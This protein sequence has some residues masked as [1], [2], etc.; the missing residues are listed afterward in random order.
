MKKK[1]LLA[2][3][4]GTMIAVSACNATE[5]SSVGSQSA[6]DPLK[7]ITLSAFFKTSLTWDTEVSKEITKR[8]GVSLEFVPVAGDASEKLN[9]MLASSDLPDI[10]SIDRGAAANNKYISNGAVIPLDDLIAKRGSNIAAQLGDTY[11][12]IK[13]TDGKLYGLPSWFTSAVQPSPVFGFNIRMNYVKELGYYDKYVDK[14]YFTRDEFYSLLKDWKAKYPTINGKETI[15]LAFNADNTGAWRLSFFGMYGLVSYDVKDDTINHISQNPSYKELYMFINQLYRD[16]L[17]DKDWPVTKKALYDEKISN[18]YV[19][20]A[21][22]AYWNIAANSIL[23]KDANG[24]NTP[25]NMMYPFKVVAN[26]VDPAKTTYG[27]TS[28]LGWTFTYISSANKNPERTLDFLDF[29]MS[30]EGQYLTQWGIEGKMWEMKD[31]KRVILPEAMEELNDDFWATLTKLG[32]RKYELLFK[33]GLAPDGQ[34]YDLWAAYSDLT[35]KRD[36]VK[37]FAVKY[38]GDSAWDTTL[39]DDLGPDSGSPEALIST[40]VSDIFNSTLPKV[41]LSGTA[42]EASKAFD[43]MLDETKKAGLDKVIEISN[44]KFQNR[45]K[46]WG[47]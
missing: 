19:L 29:L 20:C 26:G 17:L 42:D 46:V 25:D 7:P 23:G 14:G 38:L 15:P 9:L 32:I 37:E 21:P 39:Y 36:Y 6:E 10:I 45:K 5:P 28:V 12:K 1:A 27:P 31:N 18:G 22:D 3:L 16:G 2:G 4:L 40:K 13:H 24:N 34:S 43:N 30:D 47:N 33:S 11:K 8:T 41:I 44:Q 35:G